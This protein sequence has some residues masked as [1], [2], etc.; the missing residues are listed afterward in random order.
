MTTDLFTVRPEDLVDLAASLM[1]WEHIRHVPVEDDEGRLVGLVSHRSLLR[2]VGRGLEQENREP[3]AVRDIMRTN[4][5]TATPD[6]TTLDAI[7]TMRRHKVSC[8]PVVKKDRL[9]G[10]VTEHDLIKVAGRLLED[11]LREASGS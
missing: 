8:L 10:I 5:I 11:H 6:T 2:L 3:V 9:V 4:P 7:G 1:E